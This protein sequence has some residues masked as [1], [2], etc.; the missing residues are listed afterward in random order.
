MEAVFDGCRGISAFSFSSRPFCNLMKIKK[1]D[2]SLLFFRRRKISIIRNLHHINEM[3]LHLG[4]HRRKK[5][6]NVLA[7][8]LTHEICIYIFFYLNNENFNS[9]DSYKYGAIISDY[10]CIID[11]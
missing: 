9:D 2:G 6:G 1:Y 3:S 10:L 7:C 11:L 4:R 5:P 8:M